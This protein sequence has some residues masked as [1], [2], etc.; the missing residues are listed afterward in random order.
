MSASDQ[1]RTRVIVNPAA[2]AGRALQRVAPIRPLLNDAWSSIDWCVSR[3]AQH[4][5]DLCNDAATKH[6]TRVIVAGGDGTVHYA[7]RGL[8]HSTTAL[9]ILPVGTGNDFAAAAGMPLKTVAAASALVSGAIVC[10]DLAA[11]G[12]IPY[13]CVAGIGMDTPALTYINRSRLRRGKLL[14]Q[15]A[16]VKTL[17]TYEACALHIEVNGA[18][19]QE[20]V[21]FASFCNTPT[22][23]GGNRI[24]PLASI[25]DAQLDYCVF[26]DR[27]L[28]Q[29]FAI[30]ARLKLG[31]HLGHRGVR[32]GVADTISISSALPAPVTLDGELTQITTPVEI[33]LM[34]GALRLI[35]PRRAA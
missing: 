35:C 13:C 7:L 19:I 25:F 30:F 15:L 8:T 21:L 9:G 32:S 28:F 26:L 17:L 16:A 10:A 24:A 4:V 27:P 33:R 5:A 3:S 31:R 18:A 12:D 2:A 1:G 29:R 23:A 20:H 22:Y 11:A 6:Y 14:Y 34:P